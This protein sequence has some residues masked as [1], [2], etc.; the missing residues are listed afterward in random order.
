[1]PSAFGLTLTDGVIEEM[2]KCYQNGKRIQLSLGDHPVSAQPV[3]LCSRGIAKPFTFNY[4]RST[5]LFTFGQQY[6]D[7][8]IMSD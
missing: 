8:P 4:P 1:M 5:Q 3:Q 7:V 2:I 6:F